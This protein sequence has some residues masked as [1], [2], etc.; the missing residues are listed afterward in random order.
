MKL[1]KQRLDKAFKNKCDL[2]GNEPFTMELYANMHV[3]KIKYLS[4][5]KSV[6]NGKTYVNCYD[7]VNI[8]NYVL[9]CRK[10]GKVPENIALGRKPFTTDNLKEIFKKIKHFTKQK[11]LEVNDNIYKNIRLVGITENTFDNN[12]IIRLNITIGT[13]QFPTFVGKID[14]KDNF[15]IH[16]GELFSIDETDYDNSSDKTIIVIQKG[17]T[18]GRLLE[19]SHYP[20]IPTRLIKNTTN[21]LSLPSPVNI[22]TLEEN[23]KQFN[24]QLELLVA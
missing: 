12:Y 3:K 6:I 1:D 16:K 18:N 13:I 2:T 11:T 14:D 5:I 10:S 4:K 19:Q 8:Y 7:T 20:Y 23:T 21:I 22:G 17:I 9:N 24:D 15:Y